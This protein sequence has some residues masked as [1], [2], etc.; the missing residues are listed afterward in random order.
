ME[1]YYKT[2]NP[3]YRSLPEVRSDCI[4]E[5]ENKPMEII[6]PKKKSKIYIPIDIDGTR[7]KTVLEVAHRSSNA[8]IHWHL[9]E[10]YLGTT[11][12][13]HQLE[14][15]PKAGKH[16]L[17]VIDADGFQVTVEFEIEEKFG[18]K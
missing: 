9:D 10:N 15:S 11:T 14:V 17:M 5:S 18:D 12:T 4:T 16:K 2:R 8:E 6:Y 1:F 7:G 13:I 3:N